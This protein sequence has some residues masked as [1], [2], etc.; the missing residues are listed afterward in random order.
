MKKLL[1]Y[2]SMFTKIRRKW[3]GKA[4]AAANMALYEKLN[5]RY[6]SALDW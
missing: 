2:G 4:K 6:D 1:I 3:G 5:D